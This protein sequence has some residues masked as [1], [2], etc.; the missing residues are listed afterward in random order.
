MWTRHIHVDLSQV[1]FVYPHV[2]PVHSDSGL[3]GHLSSAGLKVRSESC[4]D[5]VKARVL[6]VLTLVPDA[7]DGVQ[8]S[9]LSQQ[10][11]VVL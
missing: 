1:A 8:A 6:P 10:L 3:F 9:L 4:C 5:G 7:D 2:S 11:P